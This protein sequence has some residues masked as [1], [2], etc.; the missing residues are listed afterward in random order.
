[1]AEAEAGP[2]RRHDG[3][4]MADTLLEAR[5]DTAFTVPSAH[6]ATS[7]T[8]PI[9]LSRRS[10]GR[11]DKAP[12]RPPLQGLGPCPGSA[13]TC[14]FAQEGKKGPASAILGIATEGLALDFR[15]L[16]STEAIERVGSHGDSAGR[17][18]TYPEGCAALVATASVITVP[19][20]LLER[21]G[22]TVLNLRSS[23][24]MTSPPVNPASAR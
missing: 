15:V 16:R 20:S 11:P 18:A 21:T 5:V 22:F 3:R 10:R 1:M 17:G 19:N 12:F 2:G 6:P 24:R 9:R 23:S 13:G 4:V 8:R 14:S 7:S